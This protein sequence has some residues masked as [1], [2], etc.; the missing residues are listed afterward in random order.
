MK[1]FTTKL[2]IGV[3]TIA[4]LASCSSE[5]SETT[6][7]PVENTDT[8]TVA[9]EEPVAEVVA[10]TSDQKAL[11]LYKN[12]SI[13]FAGSFMLAMSE[14]FG[15]IG[16]G[17]SNMTADGATTEEMDEQIAGMQDEML[18]KVDEM[19]AGIDEA[20]AD[21]KTKNPTVYEKMFLSDAMQEGVAIAENAELPAGFKPLTE[22][23]TPTELKRF[24]VYASDSELDADSPV[25]LMYQDLYNWSV[26]LQTGIMADEEVAAFIESLNQN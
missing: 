26:E 23:L 9:E 13:T 18:S 22:N 21:L 1:L 12:F 24:I 17:F 5:S 19:I 15:A 4:L 6:D 16:A 11:N 7:E 3:A 8:T 14:T 25:G 10:L 20:Y 2:F